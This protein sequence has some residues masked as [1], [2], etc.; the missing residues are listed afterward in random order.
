M[1]SSSEDLA[2]FTP[3]AAVFESADFVAGSWHPSQELEP[4]VLAAGWWKRSAEVARWA[5]ALYD[6]NIIDP[7]SDYLTEEW[8]V[9]MRAFAA[10]PSALADA[11]LQT[12]RTVLTNVA[13]GDR[14]CEGYMASMFTN[15]V[16]QAATRRLVDLALE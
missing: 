10:D 15:G 4:R 8:S 6:R 3:F 12:V 2:A 11:D 16:C 14:F 1:T 13:R 5:Q 9:R 7:Q